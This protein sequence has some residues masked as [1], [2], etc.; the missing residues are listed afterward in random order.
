MTFLCTSLLCPC[1]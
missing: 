1:P